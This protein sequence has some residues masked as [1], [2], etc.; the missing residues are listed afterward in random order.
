ML[1]ALSCV[2]VDVA[3][4]LKDT[5]SGKQNCEES[6]RHNKILEAIVMVMFGRL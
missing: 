4:D 1:E 3:R 5:R 6:Q 2:A